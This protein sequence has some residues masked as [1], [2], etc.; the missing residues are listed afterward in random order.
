MQWGQCYGYKNA[1]VT[2]LPIGFTSTKLCEFVSLTYQSS[3]YEV[4][5][6]IKR[7]DDSLTTITTGV[8]SGS[9]STATPLRFLILGI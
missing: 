9:S 8:Y 7:D 6:C 4:P 5:A 2:T 1:K 3:F